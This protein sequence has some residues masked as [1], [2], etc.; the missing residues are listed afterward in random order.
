[1]K[2]FRLP[3]ATLVI[4]FYLIMIIIIVSGFAGH[5]IAPPL[6]FLSLLAFPVFMSCLMGIE[7]RHKPA[8]RVPV[9]RHA[10]RFPIRFHHAA[11]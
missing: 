6:W 7:F 3:V 9:H 5:F 10:F 11:H 1:M 2:S 8:N 4:R